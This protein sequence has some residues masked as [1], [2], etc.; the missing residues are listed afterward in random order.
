MGIAL[1]VAHEMECIAYILSKKDESPWAAKILG[2][3]NSF[4]QDDR[5]HRNT[6]RTGRI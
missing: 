1:A 2:A 6:D 3:A 4:A 5:L